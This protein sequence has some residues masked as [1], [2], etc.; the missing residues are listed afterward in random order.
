[1][2]KDYMC[3]YFVNLKRT[4][5][6]GPMSI[7]DDASN[8]VSNKNQKALGLTSSDNQRSP[9]LLANFVHDYQAWHVAT[10]LGWKHGKVD[11]KNS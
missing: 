7:E 10:M 9:R 11:Q 4:W 2:Q 6:V 8:L 3:H 1:M 5:V